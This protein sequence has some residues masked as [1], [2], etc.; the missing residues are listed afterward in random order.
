MQQD[1]IIHLKSSSQSNDFYTLLLKNVWPPSEKWLS[2]EYSFKLP[3]F[4][5][6][7]VSKQQPQR[8]QST[9]CSLSTILFTSALTSKKLSFCLAFVWAWLGG[10]VSWHS[11][12]LPASWFVENQSMIVFVQCRAI[13][14]HRWTRSRSQNHYS[15]FKSKRT[16]CGG[17]CANLISHPVGALLPQAQG[18]RDKKQQFVHILIANPPTGKTKQNIGLSG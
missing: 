4:Q 2:E 6:A 7:K 11:P 1:P 9:Q 3:L 17:S 8:K 5:H 10:I 15:A 16:V 18:R 13:L 12:W 14:W